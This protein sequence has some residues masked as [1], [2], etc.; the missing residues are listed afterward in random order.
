MSGF[1]YNV[2]GFG[3]FPNRSVEAGITSNAENVSAKAQFN[4]A[5][6]ASG[7]PKIL[8]ISSGVTLGGTSGTAALTIESDLGGSLLINNAGTI[9]GTGGAAGTSGAGGNGGNAILNSGGTIVSVTNSG[10]ISGG[11]GGGGKGGTGGNGSYSQTL[12]PS[13][14]AT[15]YNFNTLWYV[16]QYGRSLVWWSGTNPVPSNQPIAY[17]TGATSASYGGYTYTRGS[18]QQ[19]FDCGNDDNC[20]T[21]SLS[22]TGNV[23]SSGGAGGN[24]GAGAGYNQSQANGSSGSAGGTNAGTGGTGGNGGDLGSNGT[25]GATGANGNSTNGGSGSAAGTAGKAI[26]GAVNFTDASGTTNGT[27]DST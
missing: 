9:T 19:N 23:S 18:F 10:T 8:N 22:R 2:L 12:G 25:A 13:Y 20:G 24:G 1:G 21:Y 15:Q 16:D 3:A 11:G 4:A 6:W 7:T 17:G 26:S 27:V 5:I 14:S